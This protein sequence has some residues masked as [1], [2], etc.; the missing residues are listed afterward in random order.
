VADV[1]HSETEDR[2]FSVGIAA[3]GVLLSVVYLWLDGDDAAIKVR[4]ISARKATQ[5][6]RG[7]Y[8]GAL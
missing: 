7:Q 3:N 2:W 6:E 5:S 8:Q 1:E 4:L